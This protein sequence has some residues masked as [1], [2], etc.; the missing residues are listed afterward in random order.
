M[1]AKVIY[2]N[3]VL[4]PLVPL[5]VTEGATIEIEFQDSITGKPWMDAFGCMTPEDGKQMMAAVNQAFGRVS[6][7]DWR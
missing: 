2:S 6:E 5:A 3:G 1:K 7:D 4:K